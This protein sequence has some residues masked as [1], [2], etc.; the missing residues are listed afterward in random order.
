[1][2]DYNRRASDQPGFLCVPGMR[3]EAQERLMEVQLLQLKDAL[4]KIEESMDRLERRLWMTVYGV[5]AIVL[6]D[7]AV[8]LLDLGP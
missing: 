7:V 1:M 2:P 3:I 8:S 5:T 6:T 4:Q